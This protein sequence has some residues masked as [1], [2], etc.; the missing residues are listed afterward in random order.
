M[1]KV[2][3]L[4]N[5]MNGL[6]PWAQVELKRRQV[7]DLASAIAHADALVDFIPVVRSVEP[8]EGQSSQSGEAC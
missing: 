2:D 1:S 3:K 7:R 5:F 6:Q 4:F 8:Q